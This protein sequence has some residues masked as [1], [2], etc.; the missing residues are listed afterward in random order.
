MRGEGAVVLLRELDGTALIRAV[1][2]RQ[3]G[4]FVAWSALTAQGLRS[5]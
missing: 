5:Y 4:N 1:P 3:F 2:A